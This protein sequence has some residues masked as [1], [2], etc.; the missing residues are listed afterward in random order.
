MNDQVIMDNYLMILKSTIEVYVHGTL[1]SSNED[2]RSLLKKGLEE[3]LTHQA[4]TYDKMTEYNWYV[5]ENVKS[6][7]IKQIL[8][9]LENKQNC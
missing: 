6:S 9:K 4:N 1:E 5:I 2:V 8:N 7:N 3:T